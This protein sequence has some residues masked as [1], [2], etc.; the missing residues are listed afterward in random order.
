MTSYRIERVRPSDRIESAS[1]E[2]II[3]HFRI[4][5]ALFYGGMLLLLFAL[6]GG[7]AGI[8][9]GA[10]DS[11]KNVPVGV[12]YMLTSVVNGLP[13][14]NA[15]TIWREQFKQPNVAVWPYYT[16]LGSFCAALLILIGFAFV[17][18]SFD[19]TERKRRSC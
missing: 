4:R 14:A 7:I 15:T 18:C 11:E 13:P 19:E 1:R 8:A 5:M 6:I 9:Y 17:G 12:K 3:R 2:K 10:D 16:L